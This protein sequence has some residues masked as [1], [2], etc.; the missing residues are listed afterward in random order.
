MRHNNVKCS[1]NGFLMMLGVQHY[2][3]CLVRPIT[4]RNCDNPRAGNCRLK[5]ACHACLH[6]VHSHLPYSNL[7]MVLTCDLESNLHIGIDNVFV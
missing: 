5:Q 3:T 2:V 4:P 6:Q 1:L 7:E